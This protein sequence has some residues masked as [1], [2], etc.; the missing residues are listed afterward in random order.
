MEI[1]LE[2]PSGQED[3][4]DTR[5][6]TNFGG[7]D[8]L[9]A[10]EDEINSPRTGRDI[11]GNLGPNMGEN[12]STSG[13][14]ANE[15][16]LGL[17]AFG[18]QVKSFEP[19]KGLE[20]ESKEAA[21]SFYREYARSVGFG[22]TI[23]ASRRSKKS[24]KFIDVKIVCSRFGSKRESST[25][26]SSR[27]CPKTDCKASMHMKRRQDGKWFIYS[28]VKEHNHEICPDDFYHTLRGRS[29]QSDIVACQ[30]KGLQLALDEVDVQVLLEYFMLMQDEFPNF[31]YAIDLDH[32]K[33][34]RNVLWVDS[35]SRHDYCNFYDAVLIDS[36][37]VRN[38]YKV[39]FVPI[40]GV[41]HHFQLMLLGCAL[42]GEETT[43]TFVWLMRTWLRAMGGQIPKVII[44]D[45]GKSLEEAI[46][47]VFPDTRHCF[48]LWHVLRKIPENLSHI[49]NRSENFMLKFNKCIYQSW[50]N[51]EFET[52]WWKMV[53]K[54][55]LRDDEWLQS[56]YRNRKKW[57][58]AYMSG[59]FLAGMCTTER[60]EYISCLLNKYIQKETKFKE[61][62]DQYK[63][64]LHDRCEEEARADFETHHNP[65]MLKSLSPFE[66]Q[67]STV[68]THAIFKKFQVEVLGTVACSLRKE[69]ED[70]AVVT[71]RVED[72][73]ERQ[74]FIVAWNEADLR[75]CCSC[76]SFEYKGFLCRHTMIVLQ[77]SGVSNIP[78]H[79]ILQRWTKDAK[80]RKSNSEI[81][82]RLHYRVQRFN[83]L[84]KR[85]IKLG[86]E[87]SL[88][89][90]T[91]DTVICALQKAMEHCVGVNNSVK[92]VL[93]PNSLLCIEEENQGNSVVKT[94][95]KKKI[96]KKRKVQSET[97]VITSGVQDSNQQ[98]GQLNS[99][100]HSLDNT[101]V[102]QQDVPGMGQL[103]SLSSIRD[104]YYSNQQ[105]IQGLGQLNSIPMR[106]G[107]YGPQQSL[108]GLL[109]GQLGFRAATMHGC[110]NIRDSLHDMEQSVAGSRQF[111]NIVSKPLQDKHLPP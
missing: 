15:N 22:I 47:E 64:F 68:Y 59:T 55:E 54:F 92:C 49:V 110:F 25:T 57:V 107:H 109:Q 40:F 61:F 2:L 51:E 37:Y 106:V 102:P 31:F 36:S 56:L 60:S 103:I 80:I 63:V 69:C 82:S 13:E 86:E 83:D 96:Y 7:T 93:E 62:I 11:E 45:E 43:S 46:T 39:P 27:S 24:G 20:F 38:K 50:T 5:L 33:R 111:Q 28:F 70:E 41:N 52:K 4:L 104:G 71:F 30:K 87:A 78:S 73:K 18:K 53:D 1:D 65:P 90:E 89:Q 16:A 34:M 81:S 35:I 84:C 8:G 101:F 77:M 44:T 21:Y 67:M 29:K 75:I 58:P 48:C 105:A 79:Y 76:R 72:F 9:L 23:K 97:E 91:Y 100:A 3:K 42:I 99:G 10:G 12:L 98:M 66:K 17:D 26:S 85:A 95:K 88:S 74:N 108:Q 32:E 19:Q 94:S 6:D 14:G